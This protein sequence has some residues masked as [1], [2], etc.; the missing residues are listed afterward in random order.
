M[1]KT[2]S[3]LTL[4]VLLVAVFVLGG[5][6]KTGPT[7]GQEKKKVPAAHTEV[8]TATGAVTAVQE[9]EEGQQ[10]AGQA[11]EEAT[12]AEEHGQGVTEKTTPESPGQEPVGEVEESPP[13]PQVAEEIIPVPTKPREIPNIARREI[14]VELQESLNRI[15]RDVN[16]SVVNI[17]VVQ[18]P[19][20]SN[21]LRNMPF[22]IPDDENHQFFVPGVGSGFIWDATGYI[23]TNNHVVQDAE[24]ISV[25]FY[26]GSTVTGTVI[27]SDPDSDLAVVKVGRLPDGIRPIQ[28]TDSSQVEVGDLVVAI[29]NP[30]GLESTM[31]VGFVSAIGRSLPIGTAGGGPSYSIPDIIQTDA[32]INPG[33][34]GGVMVD[35]QGM[36]IGVPSAI[37]SPVQASVGIGFAIPSTIVKKVVPV[38]IQQGHY[39]HPWLGIMGQSLTPEV[40]EAMGLPAEQRGALVIETVAGGPS[41]EAGIR[42][43]TRETRIEGVNV[44]IGGDVVIA[45]DGRPVKEFDDLIRYLARHTTVGQSVVL[46]VLRE[47]KPKDITVTLKARPTV[48]RVEPTEPPETV[49]PERTPTTPPAHEGHQEMHEGL[50]P[51]TEKTPEHPETHQAVPSSVW[52]GIEGKTLTASIAKEMG[53]DPGQ[54][55]VLVVQVVRDSPA[56]K[57]NLHGSTRSVKIEGETVSI[58]GDIITAMDK[59]P[60]RSLDELVAFLKT[61]QPGQKVELTVLRGKSE[62]FITVKLEPRP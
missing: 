15:Y 6:I 46:T 23:V 62:K 12:A 3:W 28:I 60:I 13:T 40:A 50:S 36:L 4:M 7:T 34:S 59:Q 2:H 5:C 48:E 20:L 11:T 54:Q 24:R 41:A 43:S 37:R 17:R 31:T 26:D 39:E 16:P 10:T 56:G 1:R 29:G 25:T 51:G 9:I 27:G 32:S 57:A 8:L 19:S 53:L 38:L 21:Q 18:R 33:N 45:F 22:Q 35:L 42:G 30:F 61:C 58:G 49:P 14:L 44:Q 47:G 55:G 52:L